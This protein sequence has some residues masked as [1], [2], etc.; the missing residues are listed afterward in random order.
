M[1]RLG[2]LRIRAGPKSSPL[3]FSPP[4]SLYCVRLPDLPVVLRDF[5]DYFSIALVIVNVSALR[6]LVPVHDA[7][8]GHWFKRSLASEKP[9]GNRRAS[10]QR[11]LAATSSR[12]SLSVALNR[13]SRI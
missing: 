4:R 13:S 3:F 2:D 5:S 8:E 11:D 6:G 10:R 12:L 7:A 9:V 1:V